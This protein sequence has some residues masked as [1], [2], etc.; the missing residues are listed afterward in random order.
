MLSQSRK[1]IQS[2]P[3]H[4]RPVLNHRSVSQLQLHPQPDL[5]R[6]QFLTHPSFFGLS[7]LGELAEAVDHMSVYSAHIEV[8]SPLSQH[9][10]LS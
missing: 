1:Q 10:R 3:V 8:V 6:L 2:D 4:E 5:R 9:R 7:L